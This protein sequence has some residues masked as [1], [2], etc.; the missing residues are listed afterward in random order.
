MGQSRRRPRLIRRLRDHSLG[1]LPFQQRVRARRVSLGLEAIF[2]SRG[3]CSRF[4]VVFGR[5]FSGTSLPF[6]RSMVSDAISLY[7]P[8]YTIL[9]L[10]SDFSLFLLSSW[11]FSFLLPSNSRIFGTDSPH[12]VFHIHR[13]SPPSIYPLLTCARLG[14]HLLIATIIILTPLSIYHPY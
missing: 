10:P 13:Y 1:R 6:F 7:F 9:W 14:T 5:C 2:S 12:N 11:P 4:G 8:V 3:W